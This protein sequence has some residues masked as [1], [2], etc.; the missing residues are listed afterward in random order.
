MIGRQFGARQDGFRRRVSIEL[1][2]ASFASPA[3]L[4][5]LVERALR[6]LAATR[7]SS[8]GGLQRAPTAALGPVPR[9]LPAP[10]RRFTGRA[11]ELQTLDGLLTEAA[12]TGAPVVISAIAGPVGIGKTALALHWAHQ[13]TDRFADG[14]LYVNLRS[15]AGRQGMRATRR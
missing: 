13:N 2:T 6:A 10:V 11:G 5:Q 14:Q 8:P 9:Q 12:A 1:T 3:Q 4:G 7:R 15:G